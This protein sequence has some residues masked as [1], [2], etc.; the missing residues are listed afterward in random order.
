MKLGDIV[1]YGPYI[2]TIISID[3]NPFGLISQIEIR[4]KLPYGCAVFWYTS[5]LDLSGARILGGSEL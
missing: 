5:P 1:L 4:W 2:G 3:F